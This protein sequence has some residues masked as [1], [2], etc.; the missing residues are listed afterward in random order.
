M[1]QV[2]NPPVRALPVIETLSGS[3]SFVFQNFGALLKI[4]S[5]PILIASLLQLVSVYIQK[6][7]FGNI[8]QAVD[9]HP[10]ELYQ[11]V[12][13]SN[14]GLGSLGILVL[15]LLAYLPVVAFMTRWHRHGI[16]IN[17]PEPR[18]FELSFNRG[19]WRFLGYSALLF[20]VAV[21]AIS[22]IYVLALIFENS[23]EMG[24]SVGFLAFVLVLI[25]LWVVF[26]RTTLVFPAAAIGARAGLKDSWRA[27]K[28]N[29]FRITMVYA[30]LLVVMFIF[31]FVWG[32]VSNLLLAPLG[33]T[34]MVDTAAPDP[35]G[36]LVPAFASAIIVNLPLTIITTACW[37]SALSAVFVYLTRSDDEAQG[38]Q[39]TAN[40]SAP[41]IED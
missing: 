11:A 3:I 33:L 40:P 16:I 24:G 26:V 32:L 25:F 37:V 9:G 13:F 18:W 31:M 30:L 10:E 1:S 7:I 19:E 41:V 4:A 39:E 6:I 22:S 29:F 27:T 23:P 35:L 28:G 38:V 34:L 17:G 21:V 12:S 14:F 20:I 2:D 5:L 15:S 36:N 8:L